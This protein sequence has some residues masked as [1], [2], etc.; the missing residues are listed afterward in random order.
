[1][2]TLRIIIALFALLVALKDGKVMVFP[3]D[4][5]LVIKDIRYVERIVPCGVIYD[6]QGTEL[7]KIPMDLIMGVGTIT[8]EEKPEIEEDM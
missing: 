5:V 6:E 4:N 3:G 1:M 7:T 2:K 8:V